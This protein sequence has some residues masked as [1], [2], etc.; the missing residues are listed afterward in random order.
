MLPLSSLVCTN[1]QN[2][3]GGKETQ[4]TDLFPETQMALLNLISNSIS[5][6][7]EVR[8]VGKRNHYFWIL[9]KTLVLMVC[10]E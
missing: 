1:P 5:V 8:E 10:F 6:T 4:T 2:I 9:K 7:M 3:L